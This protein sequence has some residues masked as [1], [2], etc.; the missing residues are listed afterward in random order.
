M[1]EPQGA[2]PG[3]G[4]KPR[5]DQ[6][7]LDYA[8]EQF[9]SQQNMPMGVVAGAV[10]ALAG[11]VLWAVITVVT[12]Y[13]IGWMAV[14]VGFGVAL[15]VRSFGKGIDRQFQ[16][17]GASLALLGCGVGN[18]L[19]V[20][21][22]IANNEGVGYFTVLSS[23][24]LQVISELMGATFSPIDILFYGIAVYEG[25][26][27]SIRQLT[28]QDIAARVSGHQSAPPAQKAGMTM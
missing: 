24:N 4:S 27:L 12:G 14:G 18:L 5:I 9:R 26:R 17:L 23:L 28:E 13:Q 7:Q 19:A 10:V 16:I 6:A 11:A 25:Y 1:N 2:T 20:C 8:L 21:G 22:M 3:Q 15:A